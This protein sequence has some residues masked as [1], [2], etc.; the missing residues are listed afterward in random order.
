MFFVGCRFWLLLAALSL[1]FLAG[2]GRRFFSLADELEDRHFG[3]VT[4]TI[5]PV[6]AVDLLENACVASGTVVEPGCDIIEELRNGFLI[7]QQGQSPSSC[8]QVAALSECNEL[9]R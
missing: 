5:S 3:V 2:F 7:W 4:Q 8:G 9:Q 6:L 1:G